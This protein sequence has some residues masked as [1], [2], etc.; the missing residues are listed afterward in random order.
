MGPSSIR[1]VVAAETHKEAGAVAKSALR[2]AAGDLG[3]HL[4]IRP[5]WGWHEPLDDKDIKRMQETY[6][7]HCAGEPCSG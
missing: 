5:D 4:D 7:R 3:I 1:L 6:R 2:N